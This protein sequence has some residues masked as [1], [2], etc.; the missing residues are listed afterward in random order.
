MVFLT[1]VSSQFE[2]RE[3]AEVCYRELLPFQD[4]FSASQTMADASCAAR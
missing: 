1:E 2:D 3:T 4:R